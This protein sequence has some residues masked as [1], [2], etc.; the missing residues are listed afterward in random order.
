MKSIYVV[1]YIYDVNIDNWP[2]RRGPFLQILT[3]IVPFDIS[4]W[5]LLEQV[6]DCE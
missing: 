6:G 4:E 2:T 1:Y 5:L 3:H